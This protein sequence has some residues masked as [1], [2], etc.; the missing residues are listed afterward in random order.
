VKVLILADMHDD[1][2]WSGGEL[3]ADLVL[4]CGDVADALVL[5]A[6]Q[7]CHC[8]RIFSV[9]GNHDTNT[10]FPDSIEDLHL[11]RIEFDGLSFGG[12][13]GSWKYKPKGHFLYEQFEAS[14]LLAGFPRVDVFVAHNSPRRVHDKEDETH[15]GFEAFVTY[16]SEKQPRLF[17]HGHQHVNRETMVGQTR[18]I[19]VFGHRLLEIAVD[20]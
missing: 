18:I 7:A 14:G 12:F 16:I 6:A 8:K 17:F 19:G 11:K 9:K 20:S 4:S 10:V 13:N 15:Y 5:E 1:F 3:V 2:H